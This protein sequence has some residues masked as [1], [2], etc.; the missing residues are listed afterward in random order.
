MG[1]YTACQEERRCTKVREIRIKT[2]PFCFI[3][4]LSAECTK[5]LNGHGKLRIRG[6][7]SEDNEEKYRKMAEQEVWVTVKLED[8]EGNEKVFFCG[9][10]TDM[11]IWRENSLYTL[12]VTVHTGSFL[13]DLVPHIRT[14]Q[15]E[16]YT[17]REIL[18]D[19]LEPDGGKFIALEKQGE[20]A[21][22]FLVQYEETDWQ[23][24]KRLAGYART[25]IIPEYTV[26]GPKMYFGYRDIRVNEEIAA[27]SYRLIQRNQGNTSREY[28]IVSREVYGLGDLVMF[29]NR[30]WVIGK[31]ASSLKGQE[32]EHV[33]T[34]LAKKDGL[35]SV[36]CNGRIRGMSLKAN[37]ADVAGTKVRIGIQGDENK[38]RSGYRW[39]DFATVYSSPDGTG[40]YCMPEIGDEVRVAFPD[41]EEGNAYVSSCVHLEADGRTNPE[42][43][44]WKN[45]QGKEI[46]FTPGA[47]ILRNNQGMSVELSDEQGIRIVSDKEIAL[48]A[49]GNISMNSQSG[50]I[51]MS[52]S[53]SMVI[54]QGGASISM[55]D[56]IR[57]G[58]GK[59]YMN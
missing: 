51:H 38:D 1:N 57:I 18:E 23:F 21:G 59:I 47:L 32:L 55:K 10:L 13:L 17:Y 7:I 50:G 14:F 40:W 44:S 15:K 45:K 58:G 46:L 48:C 3:S 42:E 41:G 37:V 31:A 29:E 26:P 27:D 34:L 12:A 49:S 33:Y 16:S 35:A 6:I 11:E 39:F 5:E 53:D 9:V 30:E 28:E 22:R 8:E 52:A 20:K 2:E 36:Q 25:V 43:K 24:A 56:A 54:S 4:L 19:C